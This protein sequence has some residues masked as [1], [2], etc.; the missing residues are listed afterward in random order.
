MIKLTTTSTAS[1]PFLLYPLR[2]AFAPL[3]VVHTGLAR[4][5]REHA[6]T[7]PALNRI[8]SA[9]AAAF[10]VEIWTD[11]LASTRRSPKRVR[12]AQGTGHGGGKSGHI[13][14]WMPIRACICLHQFHRHPEVTAAVMR[15]LLR[16]S[17]QA[18]R[19]KLP[20]LHVS[21][22]S[23]KPCILGGLRNRHCYLPFSPKPKTE[24]FD[25]A[26]CA[27]PSKSG[28]IFGVTS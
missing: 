14:N 8:L 28:Q 12:R 20:R 3:L 25:G 19:G 23:R 27:W 6:P 4:L 10:T 22:A 1:L 9:K 15:F 16:T 2:R 5:T 13:A 17:P 24:D 7:Q 18:C 21:L 26:I 11:R